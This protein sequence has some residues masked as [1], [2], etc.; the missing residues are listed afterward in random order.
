[1][2]SY[3]IFVYMYSWSYTLQQLK[4]TNLNPNCHPI[5]QTHN[6]YQTQQQLHLSTTKNPKKIRPVDPHRQQAQPK[7]HT[8]P[9]KKTKATF[10]LVTKTGLLLTP[11]PVEAISPFS[12]S[13]LHLFLLFGFFSFAFATLPYIDH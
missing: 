8:K 3:R 4:P 7:R 6:I 5:A 1:M 9:I 2:Q 13:F 11:S 12:S 10:V